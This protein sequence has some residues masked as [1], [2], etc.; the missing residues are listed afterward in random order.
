M[1][2]LEATKRTATSVT[3]Q[4][5][6]ANESEARLSAAREVYRPVA[7]RGSLLYFLINALPSLDRVYYFSMA[8][9]ALI[10]QKGCPACQSRI[11]K[12]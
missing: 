5:R 10:L 9:F 8:N 7:S 1:E 11:M 3:E 12:P 2:S 6:A 4:V